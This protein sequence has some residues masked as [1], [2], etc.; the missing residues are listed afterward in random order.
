VAKGPRSG[1][2]ESGG[3]GTIWQIFYGHNARLR[4]AF[5]YYAQAIEIE[6]AESVY[7]P[8]SGHHV[9]LFRNDA[10]Q[11]FKITEQRFLK[12]PWDFTGRPCPGSREFHLAAEVA[13]TYY[14]ISLRNPTIPKPIARRSGSWPTKRWPHG[15]WP[16][17]W[18]GTISNGESIHLHFTA[19]RLIPAGS[20]KPTRV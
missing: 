6:P 9:F 1:P 2:E 17:T 5:E 8:E 3:R 10:M 16:S 11:F 7:L 4:K 15:G 12:K 18:P 14:G 19:G 20:T 13:Q